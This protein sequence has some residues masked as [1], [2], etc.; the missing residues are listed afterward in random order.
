MEPLISQTA[1]YVYWADSA[2]GKIERVTTTGQNRQV[3]V[4]NENTPTGLAVDVVRGKMYWTSREGNCIRQ[5]NLDGSGVSTLLNDPSKPSEVC[6]DAVT[7]N[8]YWTCFTGNDRVKVCHLDSHQVQVVLAKPLYCSRS[9]AMAPSLNRLYFDGCYQGTTMFFSQMNGGNQVAFSSGSEASQWMAVDVKNGNLYVSSS[10]NGNFHISRFNLDGVQQEYSFVEC[11]RLQYI[12]G[13]AVDEA[14]G[15]FYWGQGTF[16]ASSICRM[17]LDKTGLITLASGGMIPAGVVLAKNVPVPPPPA[18]TPVPSRDPVP[19]TPLR[20]AP[21]PPPAGQLRI[22][23]TALDNF[24]DASLQ[25]GAVTVTARA[26]NAAGSTGLVT[27]LKLNGLGVAGN[28]DNMTDGSESL[29][30]TFKAPVRQ[31]ICDFS[32]TSN[33]NRNGLCAEMI[34]EAI[35]ANGVSLGMQS[36]VV[37]GNVALAALFGDRTFSSFRIQANGDGVRVGDLKFIPC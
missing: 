10:G 19:S 27:C 8:L 18:P 1:D 31:V 29:I 6:L 3:L 36:V 37:A 13:I 2:F 21:L 16:V 7:G 14:G 5:A 15:H 17:N 28:C 25:V 22:D 24:R 12:G 9:L 35:D 11:N 20:P 23:F 4:Q 26:N 33:L 34:V 30:F 32:V